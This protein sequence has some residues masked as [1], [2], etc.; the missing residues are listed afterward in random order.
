MICKPGLN[1]SYTC[2]K[3]KLSFS[4]H[5]IL[6]PDLVDFLA[7]L[8]LLQAHVI[9]LVGT[10]HLFGFAKHWLINQESLAQTKNQIKP[11]VNLYVRCIMGSNMFEKAAFC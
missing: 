6:R 11:R 7:D 1:P 2:T 10:C 5:L 9:Y 4:A 3:H 8:S